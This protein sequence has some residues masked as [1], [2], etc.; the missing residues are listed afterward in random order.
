VSPVSP[1]HFAV[2]RILLGGLLAAQLVAWLPWAGELFAAAGLRSALPPGAGLPFPTP[3]DLADG[4]VA[5]TAF[6]AGLAVL[7]LL[8]A[9]GVARRAAALLLW[10]G[11]TGLG[12]ENP[13]VQTV[14]SAYLGWLLLA[15]LLVPPGEPLRPF[16]RPRPGGGRVPRAL[17][18]GTWVV[19]AAGYGLSG[20]DK[21][22]SPAW[23]AGDALRAAVGLPYA[24]EWGAELLLSVPLSAARVATWAGLGVELALPVLA[25]ARRTRPLA[26]AAGTA[27]QL[28]LLALFAF[29][30]LTVGILLAHV[31]AFDGR[32]LAARRGGTRL[33]R[34]L[35]SRDASAGPSS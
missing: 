8:L 11:W 16:G 7:A 24:R 30:G 13:L 22:G 35:A 31:L 25:L 28:G 19:L 21:L 1:L 26:W 27:L 23:R 17:W 34:S 29:P 20:L 4:P 3:L 5:A 9:L 6:V 14:A 12:H 33:P 32:W 2:F 18:V 10:A 15:T